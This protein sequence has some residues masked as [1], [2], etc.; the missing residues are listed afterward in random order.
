PSERPQVGRSRPWIPEPILP[1]EDDGQV[2]EEETSQLQRLTWKPQRRRRPLRRHTT[3]EEGILDGQDRQQ[4]HQEGS[5]KGLTEGQDPQEQD[6]T[7]T[8]DVLQDSQI[9]AVVVALHQ[10]EAD[11]LMDARALL[12]HHFEDKQSSLPGAWR[13][14]FFSNKIAL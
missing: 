5:S 12:A 7:T 8:E 3:L 6:Q 4:D 10:G 2:R 1:S 14:Y 11:R 9:F 13:H